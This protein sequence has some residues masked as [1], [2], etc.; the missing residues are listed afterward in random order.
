MRKLLAGIAMAMLVCA[1]S[2]VVGCSSPSGSSASGSASASAASTAAASGSSASSAFSSSGAVADGEYTIGVTLSGG[3]G[4]ATVES[5]AKLM[6]SGDKMIAVIVWS[7]PNYDLMV[8]DGEQYLPVP[9]A[10]NSTFEIPV[11]ALD[12]DIAIQAET[13]AMSEPHMIDYTLRFDSSTIK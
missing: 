2:A 8:V 5:P 6:V 1:L 12:K 9:R 10:G 3:S 11:S 4:K 13:T 7:S